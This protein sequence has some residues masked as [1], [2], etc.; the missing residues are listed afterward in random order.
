M[1]TDSELSFYEN[2]VEVRYTLNG[3]VKSAMTYEQRQLNFLLETRYAT[4]VS[5]ALVQ[6]SQQYSDNL[7]AAKRAKIVRLFQQISRYGIPVDQVKLASLIMDY[8]LQLQSN[9]FSNKLYKTLEWL[10]RLILDEDGRVRTDIKPYHSI[11]GRSGLLGTTPI[12]GYKIFRERLITAPMG[13]TVVSIDYVACEIGILAAMSGDLQLKNDYL[14]NSDIYESLLDQLQNF[15]AFQLE[16]K[17]IKT[18]FLMSIY[19]ATP[20]SIALKLKIS[21]N[22]VISGYQWLT[23]YYSTAFL[24]LKHKTIESYKTKL[25]Q[26]LTWR[27]HVSE[28]ALP[29]KV[30][31]WPIQMMGMEIINH[32]C[33]L[34]DK[35]ALKIIGVVHDCI[36]IESKN[37]LIEQEKEMLQKI[38]GQASRELLHGF[39]LKTNTDFVVQG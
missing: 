3:L 15:I 14:T 7:N 12:N 4:W 39:E 13:S 34:A 38:M 30:R 21:Q 5:L 24:W 9:P 10:N 22:I 29:T 20:A 37:E 26:S 31:N 2:L 16:R 25:I 36:Y 27:I 35:Q 23:D 6:L 1:G 17:Q 32:A 28:Q 18:L 19:G 11:T 33:L 8:E